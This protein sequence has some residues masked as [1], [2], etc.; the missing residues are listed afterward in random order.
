MVKKALYI[1]TTF[2]KLCIFG[3]LFCTK[4]LLKTLCIDTRREARG[5][6]ESQVKPNEL[7]HFNYI[8]VMHY[9][10]KQNNI[11][12]GP[13]CYIQTHKTTEDYIKCTVANVQT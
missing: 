1:V 6:Q 9:I 12:P 8:L 3:T 11:S 2:L 13:W 5:N 4:L 7:S 10:V